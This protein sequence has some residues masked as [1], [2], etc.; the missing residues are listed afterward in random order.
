MP[1]KE[2]NRSENK[3]NKDEK[4]GRPKANSPTFPRDPLKKCVELAEAIEKFNAG[5]P[6]DR[7]DLAQSLNRSPDSGGFRHLITSSSRYGLTEGGYK[8]SKIGLTGL[9]SQIVAPTKEGDVETGLKQAL[10][11]PELFNNVLSYYDTKQIPREDLLK[12]TLRK[13]FDVES[14]YVDICYSVLMTNIKDYGL[15]QTIKGTDRLKLSQLSESEIKVHTGSDVE[16]ENGI[17]EEETPSDESE[18]ERSPQVIKPRQIFVAHGKNKKPLEQL[19]AILTQFHV[20]FQVAIDEPHKGRAISEKVAELMKKC[21][22]GIFIFTA[23]E[24]TVDTDGKKVLRPSDNVVFELGA[25]TV[26]YETNIIIFREEGVEFG[27]D[28]TEYGRYTFE[29][30]KLDAKALD[31]M[32]ELISQGFLQVMPR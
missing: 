23:D 27:S 21:T 5:N 30:D 16:E 14:D 18:P 13:E 19:K 26:L 4:R 15:I 31:L 3:E 2:N 8:A 9:G 24:E 20:P 28:Y 10:L 17:L 29:K 7:L 32:K 12:N 22:S 6:Y 25:G 1:N 11:T